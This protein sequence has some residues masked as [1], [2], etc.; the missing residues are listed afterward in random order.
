M[1]HIFIINPSAGG[2]K[3]AERLKKM[4]SSAA[5]KCNV[6]YSVVIT[7]YAGNATR[8][9][10]E[11]ALAR[12]EETFRFYACGGDGT[13]NEVVNGVIGLPNAECALLP[14][15][16]GN[17]FSKNFTNIENF[18]DIEKQLNGTPITIDV[19]RCNDRYSVNMI[20]I[21]FDCD[22][23]SRTDSIKKHTFLR[24]PAAY[25]AGVIATMFGHYGTDMT[26]VYEDGTEEHGEFLLSAIANGAWC[27][28][29][30]HSHPKT[31]L[32]DGYFDLCRAK[33]ISRLDFIRLLPIYKK[34]LHLE[35]PVAA[36]IIEYKKLTSLSIRFKEKIGL[37]YDGE[38]VFNDHADLSICPG[39]LRFSV[40][41]GSD[42]VV[43]LIEKAEAPATV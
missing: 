36:S 35:S 14:A 5:A 22:V 29:G 2:G 34:G 4:I 17:D 23:V 1:K 26:F 15:G 3:S 43:P 12:P 18:Q 21:G 10:R 32:N 19:I 24:G 27:G 20:N 42:V 40:P 8:I 38:I 13:L 25:G 16:T 41:Q 9:V 6:E 7:N 39:A 33:K 31:V 11:T 30:Y 28:G 37:C